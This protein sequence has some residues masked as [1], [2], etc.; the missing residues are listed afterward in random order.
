MSKEDRQPIGL[1]PVLGSTILAYAC[2]NCEMVHNSHTEDRGRQFAID[3]CRCRGGCGRVRPDVP[4]RGA[5][6]WTCDSCKYL[7]KWQ[8]FFWSLGEAAS[9]GIVNEEVWRVWTGR[10]D[11]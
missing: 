2:P 9:H 6:W 10:N 8:E 4:H 5:S 11:R 3:C 1:V 7:S